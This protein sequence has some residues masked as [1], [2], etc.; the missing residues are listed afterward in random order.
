MGE[1]FSQ[2]KNLMS[3][4]SQ[5]ISFF[6]NVWEPYTIPYLSSSTSWPR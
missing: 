6:K 2:G 1:L 4:K 3:G 5:G